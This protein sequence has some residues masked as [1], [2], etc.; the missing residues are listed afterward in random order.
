MLG[1]LYIILCTDGSYYVGSTKNLNRRI[2]QHMSGNGAKHTQKRLPV[3]LVYVEYY[4]HVHLAFRREKQIQNWSHK[5]K[6]ALISMD[7]VKLHLLAECRNDSHYK[8]HMKEGDN[9]G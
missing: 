2:H 9:L 7:Y 1:Y 8:N 5:K 4:E 3:K 6:T